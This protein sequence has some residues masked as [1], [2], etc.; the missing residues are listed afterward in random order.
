MGRRDERMD[1]Y[2]AGRTARGI[3]IGSQCWE[4][5]EAY[6]PP[7]AT[8]ADAPHGRHP[9]LVFHLDGF[10]RVPRMVVFAP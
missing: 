7:R 4:V 5:L 10:G 6:G 1:A 8:A 3:R 9:G 2:V